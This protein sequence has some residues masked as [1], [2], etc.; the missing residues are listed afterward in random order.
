MKLDRQDRPRQPQ[1]QPT[2]G[3]GGSGRRRARFSCACPFHSVAVCPAAC[4]T[5]CCNVSGESSRCSDLARARSASSS[6]PTTTTEAWRPTRR[7]PQT[8]RLAVNSSTASTGPLT[9]VATP[10]RSSASAL[11]TIRP[12]RSRSRAQAARPPRR[13]GGWRAG[14]CGD[15]RRTRRAA[16]RR[17]S[18]CHRVEARVGLVEHRHLGP[19][20]QADHDPEG[21]AHPPGQLLDRPPG[22][23]PEVGQQGVRQLG[24]PVRVEPRRDPQR[25]PDFESG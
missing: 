13:S 21:R 2:A 9:A 24:A 25:V 11:S 14:S 23:Q 19:G 6:G 1:G 10:R 7:R 18:A 8:A 4:T 3:S 16:G 22:G 15:A 12:G 17:R 20:G 5:S